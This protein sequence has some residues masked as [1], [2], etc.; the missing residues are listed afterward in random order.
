[1]RFKYVDGVLRG[2]GPE[3]DGHV[4]GDHVDADELQDRADGA[5]CDA[6]QLCTCGGQV[7]WLVPSDTLGGEEVLELVREELGRVVA[8]HRA[9]DHGGL[10]GAGADDRLEGGDVLLGLNS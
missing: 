2:V 9:E 3:G 8:V 4:A 6:V 5:L 1:M 7:V 10:V